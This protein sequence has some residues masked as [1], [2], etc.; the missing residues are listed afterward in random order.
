[1]VHSLEDTERTEF[2]GSEY[3][4]QQECWRYEKQTIKYNVVCSKAVLGIY[5]ANTCEVKCVQIA[6]K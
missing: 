3:Y 6:A 4:D 5:Q 1:M 2:Y